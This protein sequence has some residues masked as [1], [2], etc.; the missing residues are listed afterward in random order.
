M[1]NLIGTLKE[2]FGA[3]TIQTITLLSCIGSFFLGYHYQN[4][5]NIEPIKQEEVIQTSEV[6][7]EKKDTLH[8][9]KMFHCLEKYSKQYNIPTRFGDFF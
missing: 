1:K 9:V 4:H 7:S 6:V 5:K 3:L 8:S 2:I